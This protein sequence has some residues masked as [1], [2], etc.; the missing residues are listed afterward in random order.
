MLRKTAVLALAL[1][2]ALQGAAQ[3]GVYITFKDVVTDRSIWREIGQIFMA[4]AIGLILNVIFMYGLVE[5]CGMVKIMAKITATFIV[6]LWNFAV[7]KYY[8]YKI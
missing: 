3:E 1:C 2:F 8:I 5:Y 6:F 4:G 7:R